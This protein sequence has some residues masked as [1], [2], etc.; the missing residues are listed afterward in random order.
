[1]DE[2]ENS[3]GQEVAPQETSHDEAQPQA[4]VALVEDQQERNWRALREKARRAD[5]LEQRLKM[6]EEMMSKLM[7]SQPQQRIVEEPEEPDEE[8][9]PKGK[10]K[11]VAKKEVEPLE[12]RL[13]QA[14]EQLARQ[15]N[16][17]M[18]ADLKSKYRDFDEIVNIDSLA[19]FEEKEPE[20]AAAILAS[21]DPYNIAVQSYKYI[22]A[23][24]LPSKVPESKRAK[25][26][27]KKL[28]Q[29]AKTVQTPQA[30]DKRP[31][32][33]AYK[34]TEQ[35]KKALY[36]EMMQYAGQAGFSY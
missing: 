9:I 22:K 15:K 36:E 34:I 26:V 31:M 33:Q 3:V 28:E 2:V 1:M 35:E 29:N 27:E 32:A 4:K 19:L 17:L 13:Q 23:M 10:V 14:E 30:Y 12:R 8:F 6:Q 20:L 7:T 5:E 18:M 16:A 11:R 21:K 24:N 25:E